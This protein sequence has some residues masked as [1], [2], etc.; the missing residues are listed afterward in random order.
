MCVGVK[1]YI[2]QLMCW[3]ATWCRINDKCFHVLFSLL[4][5]LGNL[6]N[7]PK[8]NK[9]DFT[10]SRHVKRNEHYV[11]FLACSLSWI[12]GVSFPACREKLSMD[13]EQISKHR[14]RSVL[15]YSDP[16]WLLIALIFFMHKEKSEFFLTI[17]DIKY[18]KSLMKKCSIYY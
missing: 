17:F 2:C 4:P 6:E 15:H 12:S 11:D 16:E 18:C 1:S 9:R 7:S 5:I 10:K 8:F 13:P 14:K 3:F